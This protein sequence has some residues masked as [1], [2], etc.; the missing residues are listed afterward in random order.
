MGRNFLRI[1]LE[2]LY[3]REKQRREISLFAIESLSVFGLIIKSNKSRTKSVSFH[4]GL[5]LL[6][7][8]LDVM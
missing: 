1:N 6:V 8:L 2:K 4:S 7:L 5:L 3:P